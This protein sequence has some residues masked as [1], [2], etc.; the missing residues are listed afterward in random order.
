MTYNILKTTTKENC[1]YRIGRQNYSLFNL[2]TF[3]SKLRPQI[4]KFEVDLN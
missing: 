3:K 1:W 4:Y 2:S